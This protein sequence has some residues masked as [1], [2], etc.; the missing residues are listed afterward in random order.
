MTAEESLAAGRTALQKGRW[1]EA[2]AAFEAALAEEESPVA[3]DGMGEALWW[4]C[5]ARASIRHRERAFVG[6]KQSGDLMR[7]CATALNLSTSYLVNLGSEAAARGWLGR[8][9][10]VMQGI[11]PNPMQGWLW[12]MKGYLTSD[13]ERGREY[14]RRALE[15][16]RESGDVDLE[17]TAL[18][19]LG[20]DLVLEGKVEDGLALL[21]EAMAGTLAG[22]YERPETVVF[23]SCSM[24][25]ACS[26]V[27]DLERAA[28]WCRVADEFMRDFGCPFL[29]ARCRVHY[30]DVLVAKGQWERAESE[31]QAALGMSEDA[32]PGPRD[33]ALARLADLRFRQ[34]RFEEAEALLETFDDL[35]RGGLAAAEIRLARG[36][37]A[38]A[39]ALL[40]RRLKD[41]GDHHIEAAPTIALLVEAHIARGDTDAATV[42]AGRLDEVARSQGRPHAVALSILASA[43]LSMATGHTDVAIDLLESAVERFSRLDLPLETARA[44][45]ELAEALVDGRPELAVAEA[46]SALTA[47]DK[48]GA[49]TGA[50]AAAALLRSLGARRGTRPKHVSVLTNRE[51]EVLDLVGLGLSN[52]EIAQ[53]LFI[54]R[55]TASHH[56]SNVLSKLG[57]KNR[58]EA[59]AY[60]TRSSDRAKTK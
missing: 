52:P 54:S 7:A 57:L 39:I 42:T 48:L 3:L 2:R 56:V 32:G 9:E 51:Q 24:L 8:A 55:K 60:A 4:L 16:A 38:V 1:E 12:S 45:F 40:E 43:H 23:S 58:A 47:F 17:L 19:D 28:Q 21:D 37:P 59:A 20:L 49:T 31:L 11:D 29:Y 50:D 15:F 18:G 25:A 36:E 30:G 41:L 34:G 14:L 27:G 22:E 53:R 35:A 33:A 10:R 44:R 6:F 46:R 26:V 5:D 13:H